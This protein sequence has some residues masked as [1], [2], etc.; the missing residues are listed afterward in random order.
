MLDV[1]PP[2]ESV[3][4]WRD[5]LLHIA[6]IVIGL[7][8]AVGLEQSVEAFHRH[9]LRAETRANL[10]E[11]ITGNRSTLAADLKAIAGERRELE[12]DMVIL[13][14]LQ[15]PHHPAA[16]GELHFNWQFNALDDAAWQ[17]ARETQVLGLF[18]TAQVQGYSG[19][20]AQQEL[21]NQGGLELSRQITHAT[22]PL[23]LQPDINALTPAQVD[24]LLRSCA[25]A[26]NQ[27]AFILALTDSLDP[28]Y[29]EILSTF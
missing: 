19:T 6:T 12:A 24:E 20:Y 29:K 21:V 5:F 25:E 17:T 3:H 9:H 26:L 27:I 18:P 28:G 2:H 4:T 14:Q 15:A 23:R 8:I 16:T 1:H 7:L 10:R 13:R 22:I 11:E